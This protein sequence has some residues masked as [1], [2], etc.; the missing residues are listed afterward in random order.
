M[1]IPF[2]ASGFSDHV[3]PDEESL[4]LEIIERKIMKAEDDE[5]GDDKEIETLL[6]ERHALKRK[7][8]IRSLEKELGML[9][10]PST[11]KE[12]AHA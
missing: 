7:L 9:K 1:M 11:E 5:D 6:R 12:E 10:K 4:R 3:K 2:M 8:R